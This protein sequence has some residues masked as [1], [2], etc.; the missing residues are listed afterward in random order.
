MGLRKRG[1]T[2]KLY[3]EALDLIKAK[4]NIVMLPSKH[5]YSV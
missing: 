5:N 1:N 4:Q 3:K 2:C